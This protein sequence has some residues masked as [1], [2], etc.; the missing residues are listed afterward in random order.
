MPV[1][2]PHKRGQG[3]STVGS[4]YTKKRLENR[5]KDIDEGVGVRP[6]D[7]DA[8]DPA[9]KGL[10]VGWRVLKHLGVFIGI[11]AISEVGT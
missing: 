4:N 1:G 11:K 10:R 3:E 6:A 5:Q 2:G 9:G 7:L 8:H